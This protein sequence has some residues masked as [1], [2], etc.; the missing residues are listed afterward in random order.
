MEDLARKLQ[1]MR[2]G[3]EYSTGQIIVDKENT[4]QG[5]IR[6]MCERAR[7]RTQQV[8]VQGVLCTVTRFR[9]FTQRRPSVERGRKEQSETVDR[10]QRG[11]HGVKPLAS[12]SFSQTTFSPLYT[13]TP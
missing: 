5:L 6:R 9:G 7:C 2:F 1:G 4:C 12:A 3:T 13:P 11:A 10:R 8:R